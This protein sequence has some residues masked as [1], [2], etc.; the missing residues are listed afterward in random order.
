ME[1]YV[2]KQRWKIYLGLMA[3]MIAASTLAYT[4]YLIRRLSDEEQ[5]KIR[6]WAE[7][8]KRRA[9]LVEV[10]RQLFEWIEEDERTKA[11]IIAEATRLILESESTDLSFYSRILESNNTI[12][13]IVTYDDGKIM[14]VRNLD[15][16]SL[17]ALSRISQQRNPIPLVTRIGAQKFTFF[18]YYDDSRIYKRLRAVM[19][20][21][22]NSFISET[23][24]NA[25]SVPVVYTDATKQ[26]ILAYGNIP[27]DK[28]KKFKNDLS[29]IEWVA[30]DNQPIEVEVARGEKNYIFYKDSNVLATL[31]FFPY[32]QLS[33][34][35]LFIM[36]A[37][38]MFS[39]ARRSE[40]NMVWVGMS[41]ETAH[42]LG[43]PISSLMG[44]IEILRLDE[45]YAHIAEEMNK[46][47]TRLQVV[48]ER[49]SKIGSI[50]ELKPEPIVTV[51][52][53]L[54]AYFRERVPRNVILEIQYRMP[55]M[56]KVKI[57]RPLFEW[58]LENL[59]RN[60]IDAMPGG[61]SV[62]YRLAEE[63]NQVIVD[64]TDTGFGIPRKNWKRIFSPGFTTRRRGWGLGLS[65]S[66]RIVEDY[67]K[68]KIFVYKSELGKG[69]TIRIILKK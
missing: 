42:Q 3:L 59:T 4:G 2:R 64:I 13:I 61:G 11:Q 15:E 19:D 43:T 45:K 35:S 67:H 69:T 47:I 46:D 58:V 12:P 53:N 55:I 29:L 1:P 5:N 56:E 27:P 36:V 22:V 44:W 51:V 28:Q 24:S 65:L 68:G 30:S 14:T 10:T 31:R 66:R 41:K 62:Q 34:F 40:E 7:A 37:Y 63:S 16:D 52:E 23:V 21:L 26:R 8:V 54:V 38:L 48:A 9:R 32:V 39:T 49:F 50:P 60:S 33:I 57:N 20:D 17:L 6:L 25:A 18:L